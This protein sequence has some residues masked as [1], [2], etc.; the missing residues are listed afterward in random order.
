MRVCRSKKVV[1]EKHP[2]TFYCRRFAQ[3]TKLKSVSTVAAATKNVTIVARPVPKMHYVGTFFKWEQHFILKWLYNCN[4]VTTKNCRH[5][6]KH[7]Q[8]VATRPGYDVIIKFAVLVLVQYKIQV[9]ST[10]TI[11]SNVEHSYAPTQ[12]AARPSPAHG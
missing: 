3:K 1:Q 12:A 9:L 8:R 7:T 4:K 10:R 5:T 11:R 2:L 6:H